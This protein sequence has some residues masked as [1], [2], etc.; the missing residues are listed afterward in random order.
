MNKTIIIML[1]MIMMIGLASAELTWDNWKTFNQEQDTV[2]IRDLNGDIGTAQIVPCNKW[3]SVDDCRV[4]RGQD[5]LVMKFKVWAWEDYQGSVTDLSFIN[6]YNGQ[7][8]T[9]RSYVWKTLVVSTIPKVEYRQNC[10]YD[11][12][13]VVQDAAGIYGYEIIS[14]EN[15]TINS[16]EDVEIWTAVDQI[17]MSKNDV[18]TIG[19][20]TDVGKGERVDSVPSLYGVSIDE[21]ATFTEDLNYGLITR[22]EFSE[23]S[24]T[25]L[26]DERGNNTGTTNATPDLNVEGYLGIGSGINITGNR[27][28]GPLTDG[29]HYLYNTL[30][31]NPNAGTVAFWMKPD[32]NTPDDNGVLQRTA[33]TY[34]TYCAYIPSTKTITC[35]EA[36]SL[37]WSVSH[38]FNANEEWTHVVLTYDSTDAVRLYVNGTE[39]D[40]ATWSSLTLMNQGNSFGI[41]RPI[42][43]Y[44]NRYSGL[45]DENLYYERALNATE[46]S[47]LYS[48][49]INPSSTVTVNLVNPT[50]A[51][52]TGNFSQV[53]NYTSTITGGLSVANNTLYIWNSTGQL[54]YSG[55]DTY[56]PNINASY[57]AQQKQ[58][59]FTLG[60]IGLYEWNVES[61]SNE[62]LCAFATGNNTFELSS[63][64]QIEFISP[65]P[66]DNSTLLISYLPAYTNYTSE[67]SFFGNVTINVYWKDNSTLI[68]SFFYNES[69]NN[70][71]NFT[72]VNGNYS[73]NAT[74][75]IDNLDEGYTETRNV[76]ILGPSINFSLTNPPDGEIYNYSN[77]QYD[78]SGTSS[79]PLAN[80]SLYN[81]QSGSWALI[82][83][84]T[85]YYNG[86]YDPFN[87]GVDDGYKTDR[88]K[89]ENGTVENAN[90]LTQL[91]QG[92]FSAGGAIWNYFTRGTSASGGEFD[93]N[94]TTIGLPPL[95]TFNNITIDSGYLQIGET[96][97]AINDYTNL[98]IWMLGEKYF[99]WTTL[100]VTSQSSV[101]TQDFKIVNNG[102]ENYFDIYS[103]SV[104]NKT[105]LATN[106]ELVFEV[107]YKSH[108][109][110][111]G[112]TAYTRIN[113]IIIDGAYNYNFNET[114]NDSTP[115]GI[116]N[117]GIEACDISG[118]CDFSTNN[119][120]IEVAYLPQI[121]Y[122]SNTPADS[123]TI[124]TTHIPVG[125][126]ETNG[127]LNTASINLYNSSGP[128]SSY[129]ATGTQNSTNFTGII[130]G[131]YYINITAS[132]IL[133]RTVAT[134][135]RT[136]TKFGPEV[137]L[138][139]PA[140]Q[141]IEPFPN[142]T[143]TC[144]AVIGGTEYL[145]NIKLYN[146]Q[147]GS[148]TINETKQVP[149]NTVIGIYDPVDKSFT[150][151]GSCGTEYFY[152]IADDYIETIQMYG[153]Q[154]YTVGTL[155][156]T[157]VRWLYTNGT[158]TTQE[159]YDWLP[160]N[161]LSYHN[162]TNPHLYESLN[163]IGV[164]NCMGGGGGSQTV[165][166]LDTWIW[167]NTQQQNY[168]AEFNKTIT[169]GIVWN[170][171]M[172]TKQ[173]TTAQALTNYTLLYDTTTPIITLTAPSNKETITDGDTL[174]INWSIIEANPDTCWYVYDGTNTTVSC[175]A[176]T[177]TFTYNGGINTITFY[178]N[179]TYGNVGSTTRI[180]NATVIIGTETYEP[181]TVETSTEEFTI[182]LIY[183]SA[184]WSSVLAYLNYDGTEYA[185][186][187]IGTGD[188]VNFIRSISIP[189]VAADENKTFYWRI[190][191]TNATASYNF[192]TTS[193]QQLVTKVNFHICNYSEGPQLFFQTYSTLNPTIPVN[194]TFSSAWTI[195]S[196]TGGTVVLSRSYEDLT[197]TN[198]TWGFCI[199]P[200]STAYTVS[201][202]VQVDGTDYTPTYHYIVDTDYTSTGEN[203]TLYLLNESFATLTEIEV[204]D[205]DFNSLAN[206][207]V[208]AQRYDLGTDT[209]YNVDMAR[210]SSD[211]TDLMYLHWYDSWY[212][213]VLVYNGEVVLTDGP[214]KVSATPQTFRVGAGIT[215]DYDKYGNILYNLIFN[216]T[217]D[218]YVLTYIDPTGQV[219]SSC[220]KVIKRNVTNDYLVCETCEGSSS[221]T[222]Y[223]NIASWGNGT[224]IGQYYATG[225]PRYY[226][227][228]LQQIQGAQ[229]ELYDLIGNDDGTGLAIIT[230]GI[231]LTLFLITPAL[232][233]LGAILGMVAAV[234]LGFQPLDMVTYAGIIIVGM[235]VMWAVDRR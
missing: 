54:F 87:T 6:M 9:S 226:I 147:S 48:L 196:S 23:T 67:P 169:E 33:Q 45:I 1:G 105:I 201:V 52:T 185:G 211:G 56:Y 156:S 173:G 154:S 186:T 43:P 234:A 84:K 80:I 141:T 215:D 183:N 178:A 10:T 212:K 104:Y 63:N 152:D 108:D 151:S 27:P 118:Y 149:N 202:D 116:Y 97:G 46:V 204:T 182:G 91:Q 207:Y 174:F 114:I 107:S 28:T 7:E 167:N 13:S 189:A 55:T 123:S 115:E 208:T 102:T 85:L 78:I 20:F 83:N 37:S 79:F 51:S 70:G 218:N 219:S 110:P 95:G 82:K 230:A 179:D 209:Y 120:T 39:V 163:Q 81:N 235:A 127:G 88:W 227:D 19:L 29:G 3:S 162:W 53:F 140:D 126:I 109:G 132:D 59:N 113:N 41:N 21:W 136:I 220:L 232:G 166:V 145:D 16:N 5:R 138:I 188:N 170:C 161:V 8:E 199:E 231:V 131:E 176:L 171:E 36:N 119:R 128:V 158:N 49:Y 30:S 135:T 134:N 164:Q 24:G 66:A 68:S 34:G 191:L 168:T 190:R 159:N 50:N 122:D 31:M 206:V 47:D 106:N 25:T 216:E 99:T 60:D 32:S 69:T 155:G 187:A 233:V 160:N 221:A 228:L 213:F 198:S 92:E 58:I 98:T 129:S 62:S 124:T 133:G 93:S 139:S 65:T 143:F 194:A 223:C 77:V 125:Y 177:D 200:N 11:Y 165:E 73:Y 111:G 157:K 137:T 94:M 217:T 72:L 15:I 192:S 96:A 26:A 76:Q 90:Q 112:H 225:S 146:N 40:N 101:V 17:N 100:G 229:N 180:W 61:C 205:L 184:D 2:T 193:H 86:T 222:L 121:E 12:N 130:N 197:E 71:T 195:K 89:F 148:W 4:A 75:I 35:Y 172:N 64:P 74:V 38:V 42:Y 144:N 175:T 22:Y 150:G 153:R 210:T 103:N 18:L 117:W 14:C 181:E 224:F 57:I 203:I 214:K 142:V 44:W